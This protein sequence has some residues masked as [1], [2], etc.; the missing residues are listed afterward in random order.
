MP[1]TSSGSWAN[2]AQQ[3]GNKTSP[4]TASKAAANGRARYLIISSSVPGFPRGVA[5][6]S[7][8]LNVTRPGLLFAMKFQPPKQQPML[9][10][11]ASADNLKSEKVLVDP[12]KIDSKGTDRK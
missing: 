2:A 4:Q 3:I 10:T 12:N 7:L 8:Q 11:L 6:L 9:V 5:R 1:S